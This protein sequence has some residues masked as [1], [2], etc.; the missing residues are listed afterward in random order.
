[1]YNPENFTPVE[2]FFIGNEKI[3]VDKDDWYKPF[4]NFIPNISNKIT[5]QL[6]RKSPDNSIVVKERPTYLTH[7]TTVFNVSGTTSMPHFTVVE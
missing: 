1:M 7:K 2:V 5:I 3:R 6:K 4:D